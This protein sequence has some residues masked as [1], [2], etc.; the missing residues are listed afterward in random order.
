MDKKTPHNFFTN[1]NQPKQTYKDVFIIPQYTEVT[2]RKSVDVSS[3]GLNIP[4]VSS[5]MDSISEEK[6]CT[7]LYH[8]GAI[9]ALHRFM[10]IHENIKQFKDIKSRNA[11]AFC[12]VGVN[13]ESKERAKALYQAGAD[14]LIIDIAHGHSKM[15]KDMLIWMR[16]EFKNNIHI[17]AGNIA[18]QQA[19]KDLEEWGADSI[20][21]FIGPGKACLTKNITG[22]TYPTFS[23]VAECSEVASVPIIADGGCV[24]IGDICKAIGAGASAVM[25]GS[26]FFLVIFILYL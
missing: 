21:I 2:S 16:A 5:N 14:K 24:E 18:T 22:V 19:V 8:E 17:M 4:V 6:M 10:P 12:S 9:G 1:H 23:C 15:L 26:L 11:N 7:T 13:E 3:F 20:K 25:I